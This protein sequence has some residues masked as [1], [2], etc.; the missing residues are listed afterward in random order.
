MGQN[1]GKTNNNIFMNN[2][3][4]ARYPPI[5]FFTGTQIIFLL[6]TP[7]RL[8][9][10]AIWQDWTSQLDDRGLFMVFLRAIS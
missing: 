6:K 2:A 5:C 7:T 4:F 3:S 10:F 8:Y 9:K 1:K